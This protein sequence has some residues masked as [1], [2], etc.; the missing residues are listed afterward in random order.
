MIVT[1]R[2]NL[3]F[4]LADVDSLY[5]LQA[6]PSGPSFYSAPSFFFA[7][8]DG[9]QLT[10]AMNDEQRFLAALT[11]AISSY[12]GYGFVPGLQTILDELQA[13]L[14]P[15]APRYPQVG[16][17]SVRGRIVM[18]YD[19]PWFTMLQSSTPPSWWSGPWSGPRFC[20]IIVADI[21]SNNYTTPDANLV[22]A[23]QLYGAFRFSF[24]VPNSVQCG[25]CTFDIAEATD[26]DG[27]PSGVAV[28][29]N[30][31]NV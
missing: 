27:N 2:S 23:G 22:A 24:R 7:S 13:D 10:P 19:G 14:T 20:G 4:P 18:I 8:A 16:D 31:S 30:V 26:K 25:A 12:S 11:D 6:P 29:V 5:W 1:T 15:P 3:K 17:T 28:A 21:E 9:S